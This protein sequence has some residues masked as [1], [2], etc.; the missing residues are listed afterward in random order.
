MLGHERAMGACGS[1]DV[2]VLVL[3]TVSTHWPLRQTLDVEYE[4]GLV[5][6]LVHSL[7]CVLVCGHVCGFVHGLGHGLMCGL[8]CGLVCGPDL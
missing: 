7:V 3:S 8:V 6:G 1:P 4:L 2:A 5:C